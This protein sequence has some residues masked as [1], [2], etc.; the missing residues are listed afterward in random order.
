MKG[1]LSGKVAITTGAGLG[2]GIALALAKEGAAVLIADLNPAAAEAVAK[3]IR[4]LGGAALA[5]QCDAGI[6]AEVD[7]SV[8]AAVREFGT[9][10]ILVN[11]AQAAR[12]SVP[13]EETTDEDMAL[14]WESGVLGTY[15]FMQACFPYL[16]E[17]GGKVINFGSAGGTEGIAGLAAYAAAKEAIRALTRVAAHEWGRFRI[18]VNAICPFANS[19]IGLKFAEDHPDI[20][21]YALSR[22]PL[23]R[24]GDCEKDIGR[25]VVFLSGP[26]SDFITGMTIMVDGGQSVL[27]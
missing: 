19:P 26:D 20:F 22:V 12:P 7:R 9:V 11:T 18:N 27:R 25:A 24:I 3:E 4:A 23:G 17:R 14:A 10:D 21:E 2:K 13:F 6:R 16:K 1:I 5:V 8:A 15:Y